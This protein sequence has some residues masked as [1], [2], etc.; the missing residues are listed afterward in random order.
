[1]NPDFGCVSPEGLGEEAARTMETS[2]CNT[3]YS[4]C[5][6]GV[7]EAQ[8]GLVTCSKSRSKMAAAR[9][10]IQA[11]FPEARYTPGKPSH[12]PDTSGHWVL[13]EES[14]RIAISMY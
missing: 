14:R 7:V 10:Q 11:P 5:S 3:S 12:C 9:T 4:H 13:I 1:M 2:S 6:D 8:R